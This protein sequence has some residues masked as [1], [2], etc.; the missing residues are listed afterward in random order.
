MTLSV[1]SSAGRFIVPQG[2]PAIHALSPSGLIGVQLQPVSDQLH[3]SMRGQGRHFKHSCKK[4]KIRKPYEYNSAI[5][6]WYYVSKVLMYCIRSNKGSNNRK[7]VN[8]YIHAPL[9]RNFSFY[10]LLQNILPTPQSTGLCPEL[11]PEWG[12]KT[13]EYKYVL[14]SFMKWILKITL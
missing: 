7:V 10:R 14:F 5:L 13:A 8:H 1:Q 11:R 2:Y 9:E 12:G 3:T 6:Q 4:R